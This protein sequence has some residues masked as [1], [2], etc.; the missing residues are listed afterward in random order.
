MSLRREA[1][2]VARVYGIICALRTGSEGGK[3][4]SLEALGSDIVRRPI[5]WPAKDLASDSVEDEAPGGV[6]KADLSGRGSEDSE[7][8]V[9]EEE[10]EWVAWYVLRRL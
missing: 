8:E 1:V 6:E 5:V 7:K 4:W 3:V 10:E 2:A 9:Q